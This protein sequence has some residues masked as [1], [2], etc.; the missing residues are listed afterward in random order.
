[1]KL[2][3][4]GVGNNTSALVQ[5]IG[6][7][8]R[9]GGDGQLPGVTRP[10]LGGVHVTDIDVVAA[11]D[12]AENKTGKLL[13]E[14]I[15]AA[16]NNY[17]VL[18]TAPP[19]VDPEVLPGIE[20]PDDDQQLEAVAK[21]LQ[22]Q[23]AEVLLYSLPTG[24][25]AMARAYGR[26]ALAAGVAVVNCT[27]D[28]MASLPELQAEADEK[29][30]PL[31]GDDLQSHFGSSIVHGALLALLEERGL[32]LSGSYQVNMGGNADFENLRKRGES[33]LASKHRALRQKVSR[34]DAVTVIPS[35]GFVSHLQ[36]RKVAHIS[37]E[38]RGWA[39]MPVKLDV[40]LQVQDSS[41]AA[42]VIIDLVRIAAV[43][44]ERGEGGFPVAATPLLKSPKL[45][46]EP[47]RQGHRARELLAALVAEDVV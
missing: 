23:E 7:Y 34:T 2:A 27:P 8:R 22:A 3:V 41:N 36:D 31:V 40:T 12:L 29:A 9:G 30:I 5:G 47:V 16:P 39:D 24:L 11:F 38:A 32:H 4:A 37:V 13:S 21:V 46:D 25:P 43:A 18:E 19:R 28:P 33:K 44:R 17:P 20:D 6:F 26:A 42:G 10:V 14:A 45:V 15:F 1:M 35:A